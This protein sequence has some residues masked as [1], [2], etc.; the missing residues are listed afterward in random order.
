MTLGLREMIEERDNTIRKLS[1]KINKL[2][3]TLKKSILTRALSDKER[4]GS[5]DGNNYLEMLKMEVNKT[6]HLEDTITL[7]TRRI[8]AI[9]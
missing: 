7:I 8:N 4:Q 9:L 5:G 6:K 2:E 3:A 1:R